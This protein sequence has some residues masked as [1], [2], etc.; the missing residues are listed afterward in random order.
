MLQGPARAGDERQRGVRV[1]TYDDRS[2]KDDGLFYPSTSTGG[3]GATYS[4]SGHDPAEEAFQES[5]SGRG[6]PGFDASGFSE[7]SGG[8]ATSVMAPAGD[9]GGL[10][11]ACP[12][13][14][15]SVAAAATPIA[16]T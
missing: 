16:G 14:T 6:S 4:A 3:R 5:G 8:G 13:P 10:A 9:L 7:D 1:S 2:A 12:P 15:S 11:P